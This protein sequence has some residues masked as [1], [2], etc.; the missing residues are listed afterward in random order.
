MSGNLILSYE[1]H[2]KSIM[3]HITNLITQFTEQNVHKHDYYQNKRLFCQ[4]TLFKR[5]I[6]H[7]SAVLTSIPAD[8]LAIL[9]NASLSRFLLSV[10]RSSFLMKLYHKSFYHTDSCQN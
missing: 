6:I 1:L 10:L 8:F 2:I 5:L 3:L 4:I 9:T 7:K